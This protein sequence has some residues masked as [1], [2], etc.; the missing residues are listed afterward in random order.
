MGLRG[1]QDHYDAYVEDFTISQMSDGSKVVEFKEN[2][3]KTRQGG[4]RNATR[5]SPQQMWSTDGGEQDP[6]KLF[7]EWLGHRPEALTKSG[8]LYLSIIPRPKTDVWYTKTRMG[9][10]RISQIMKS[11][12]SC[13]PQDCSKK[14]TNHSTRKAVVAKRQERQST[15][16]QDHPSDRPCSR[17]VLGRLRRSYPQGTTRIIPHRLR[18]CSS[19]RSAI[20]LN[21]GDFCRELSTAINK[22]FASTARL[23]SCE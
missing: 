13:L 22:W 14:I 20:Q 8:P 4:L 17:I 19:D 6:V 5:H 21:F 7:E 3:T 16:P 9:Q 12:A 1:R 2:P 10:H 15:S 11:V 18:I 23:I